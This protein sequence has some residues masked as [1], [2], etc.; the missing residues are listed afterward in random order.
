MEET[1]KDIEGYIGFYQVSNMGNVR[2]LDRVVNNSRFGKIKQTG[3]VL[4]S[5]I[6]SKGYQRVALSKDRKL[7]T[8]KV[9]RLVAQAFLNNPSNLAEVNHIAGNKTDNKVESLEWIS[10][11]DNCIHSFANGLQIGMKKESNPNSKLTIEKVKSARLE[12]I[13][14]VVG[15]KQ[16]A[17][18]Y[19]VDKK[20]MIQAI[21]GIT[22]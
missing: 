12:Y 10:H 15:Y 3:R 6:D 1:W 20:T 13:P 11:R 8:F 7:S 19:G 2:S 16:L 17:D 4:K 14:Y 22:W 9:H 21:K 18:K 5:A